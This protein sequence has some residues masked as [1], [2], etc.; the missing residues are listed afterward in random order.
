MVTAM[1]R[2][3]KII[4]NIALAAVASVAGLCVTGVST[5]VFAQSAGIEAPFGDKIGPLVKNYNRLRPNI[6]TG[7]LLKSGALAMLKSLGFTT[8]VDLRGPNEG[9]EAERKAAEAA[10]LHY[11]NIPVTDELPS[12]A[13]IAEFGRIVEDT[14]HQPLLVHCA[15]ANRV[16][17]IWTLYRVGTGV[18]FSIAVEEGRTTGMQPSRENAV[19]KRLGELAFRR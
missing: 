6:A 16:G 17:T 15:S 13:Q 3:P 10:G 1:T 19:R 5:P 11:F 8:I 2:V 14:K 7:G 4:R 9:P 12:S 18:P